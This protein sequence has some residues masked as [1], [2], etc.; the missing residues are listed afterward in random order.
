MKMIM[1]SIDRIKHEPELRNKVGTG[2]MSFLDEA[3]INI[4]HDHKSL[5]FSFAGTE[6][7]KMAHTQ[8]SKEEHRQALQDII[9]EL[10]EKRVDITCQIKESLTETDVSNINLSKVNFDITMAE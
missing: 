5:V 10:T 8:F 9:G 1:A 2:T 3:S 4:G 7:G 6:K